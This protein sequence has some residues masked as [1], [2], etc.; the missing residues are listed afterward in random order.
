MRSFVASVVVCLGLG[1]CDVDPN[2]QVQEAQ[3]EDLALM[4]Q[5]QMFWTC[6]DPV[7]SGWTNKGLKKCGNRQAGDPCQASQIGKEC[8]PHDACNAT[9]VCSDKDPIG[10]FGCPISRRAAKKD[11]A[12]ADAMDLERLRA[13]LLDVRLATYRYNEEP[14]SAKTHLGFV[15]DDD[16]TSPAV[17]P[18]GQ[19][20]DLY[21]YTSMAVATIQV[22]Q[23]QIEALTRE[24]EA[25]KAARP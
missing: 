7:C 9:L 22:Q 18:N 14:E 2:G 19:Q 13:Q 5:P 6:G 4:T 8:D 11:I 16:P 20:V 10:P 15:I 21:A 23:R 25:L 12:Y 1:S 17:A 3:A 24:V